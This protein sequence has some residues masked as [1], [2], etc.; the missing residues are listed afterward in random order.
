MNTAPAIPAENSTEPTSNPPRTP[1]SVAI[2]T[3]HKTHPTYTHDGK[4]ESDRRAENEAAR[5][6]D[7]PKNIMLDKIAE[8]LVKKLGLRVKDAASAASA[9]YELNPMPETKFDVESGDASNSAAPTD[10]AVAIIRGFFHSVGQSSAQTDFAD[11]LISDLLCGPSFRLATSRPSEV[12]Y[13]VDDVA[14]RLGIQRQAVRDCVERLNNAYGI[15][16]PG[17]TP[18]ETCRR[19]S[20]GKIDRN[21]AA[22]IIPKRRQ[23]TGNPPGAPKKY[24]VEQVRRVLGTDTLFPGILKERLRGVGLKERTAGRAMAA[25]LAAG[26]ALKTADGAYRRADGANAVPVQS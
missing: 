21:R 19:I 25:A 9:I 18:P 12:G 20:Q 1:W 6:A 22:G 13:T 10:R 8:A 15:L 17:A 2:E 4:E 14:Q 3:K 24:D 7:S 11:P 5:P 26:V 23:R 16:R